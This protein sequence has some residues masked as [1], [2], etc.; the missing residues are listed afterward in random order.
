MQDKTPTGL[1]APGAADAKRGRLGLS[2]K[3]LLLTLAVIML[4][5]VL[6]FVPSVAN[7]RQTWLL[8]RLRYSQIATEKP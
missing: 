2:A 3:L 6:V 1:A 7:F 4:T 8:E 5:E